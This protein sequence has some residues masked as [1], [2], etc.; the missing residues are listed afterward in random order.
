MTFTGETKSIVVGGT[1]GIGHAVSKALSQPLGLAAIR[2]NVVSPGLTNTKASAGMDAKARAAMLDRAAS[3]LPAGNVGAP[4][5]L[6][7][8][9]LFAIENPFVTGAVIDIDGGALIN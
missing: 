2:V 9:Y 5:D 4:E 6:A 3:S 8:G 7:Q 1:S